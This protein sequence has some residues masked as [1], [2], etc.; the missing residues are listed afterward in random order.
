MDGGREGG[1]GGGRSYLIHLTHGVQND[2]RACE[3]NPGVSHGETDI[4]L[5]GVGSRDAA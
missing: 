1:R 5:H 2:C 4:G 3:T